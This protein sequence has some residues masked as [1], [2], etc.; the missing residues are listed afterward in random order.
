M[1]VTRADSNIEEEIYTIQISE[2]KTW[3]FDY[4][5]YTYPSPD[6][7]PSIPIDESLYL[8]FSDSNSTDPF[9]GNRP[10]AC[11]DIIF[12]T[13]ENNRINTNLNENIGLSPVI[14][15]LK[16]YSE[17]EREAIIGNL[18]TRAQEFLKRG[19]ELKFLNEK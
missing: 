6:H 4:R 7:M 9:S 14:S 15:K 11:Q 13:K 10:S 3:R 17:S 18:S 19:L 1:K 5:H 2:G 8:C 12:T 16:R